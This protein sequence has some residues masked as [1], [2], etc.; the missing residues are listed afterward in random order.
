[1]IPAP[2]REHGISRRLRMQAAAEL[3]QGQLQLGEAGENGKARPAAKA[4]RNW[5]DPSCTDPSQC[6]CAGLWHATPASSC[7]RCGA[8]ACQ[9]APSPLLSRPPLSPS[10]GRGWWAWSTP[11]SSPSTMSALR[12]RQAVWMPATLACSLLP[13][14]RQPTPAPALTCTHVCCRPGVHR[15]PRGALRAHRHHRGDDHRGLG[16]PTH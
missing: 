14:T 7:R 1:M 3:L 13:T 5:D 16:Y 10:A 9:P 8:P 4:V 12:V 15:H 11:G 6:R 2:P